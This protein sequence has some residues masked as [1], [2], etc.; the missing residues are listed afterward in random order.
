MKRRTT[1][2]ERVICGCEYCVD[3]I[4]HDGKPSARAHYCPYKECIYKTSASF[5]ALCVKAE[6]LEGLSNRER[7]ILITEAID[8]YDEDEED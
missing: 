1:P 5:M 4:T 7:E 2:K 8:S 6:S 3:A